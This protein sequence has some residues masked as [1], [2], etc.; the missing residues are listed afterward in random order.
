VQISNKLKVNVSGAAGI[1]REREEKKLEFFP[2][3]RYYLPT[4]LPVQG[5]RSTSSQKFKSVKCT[6]IQLYI[7]VIR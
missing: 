2:L 3:S 4:Y 5:E 6:N 1:Y 7:P